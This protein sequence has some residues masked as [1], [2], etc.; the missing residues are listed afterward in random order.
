MKPSS[1]IPSRSALS[2]IIPV[3]NESAAI[4][5]TLKPLTGVP[6]VEVIVVDGGS[7]DNTVELAQAGG[8][9][10]IQAPQA[11]RANQLNFGASM[12]QGEILLFLHADT[13][14]PQDYLPQVQKL[15]AQPQVIAGAFSLRI[16]ADGWD[17]RLLEGA[18]ALRSRLLSLPYGDQAIFMRTAQFKAIGGFQPLPIMEDFELIQRLK[19]QGKIAIAH[20]TV[21]TSSRRW[22]KL[23]ILR[24]TLINQRIILGYSLGV[25]PQRLVDWYQRR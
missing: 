19:R 5:S 21:L 1:P 16:A 7:Q 3:L 12:A 14:L 15:L 24:T 17:Y 4:Q 22:Q 23:G 10:I 11:G 8:A 6:E 25:S 18:I 20:S 13:L 2:I 9:T